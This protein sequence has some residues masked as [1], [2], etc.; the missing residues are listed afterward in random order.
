M[1]W[2][3]WSPSY[4]RKFEPYQIFYTNVKQKKTEAQAFADY[5]E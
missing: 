3:A 1:N 5:F 4:N 2:K